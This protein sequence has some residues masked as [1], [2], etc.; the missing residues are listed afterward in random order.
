MKSKEKNKEKSKIR[1]IKKRN[2]EGKE[3][4]GKKR[5]E[6][7]PFAD[8]FHTPVSVFQKYACVN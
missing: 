1:K 7:K 2:E 3:I 6:R 4:K 5:D 8:D